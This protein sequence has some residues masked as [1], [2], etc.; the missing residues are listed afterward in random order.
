M[1]ILFYKNSKGRVL[2]NDWLLKKLDPQTKFRIRD[3]I[4]RIEEYGLFGDWKKIDEEICELRFH[5]GAGYR[6]YFYF[7]DSQTIIILCGG[8]KSSQSTDIA[9]ARQYLEEHRSY[10]QN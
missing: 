2:F 8:D 4:D 9:K 3:R 10:E 6:V 1:K 7:Y 5:F